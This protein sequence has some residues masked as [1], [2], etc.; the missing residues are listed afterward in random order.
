MSLRSKKLGSFVKFVACTLVLLW[1]GSAS[2]ASLNIKIAHGGSLEHQYHIG[3][4]EFKRL[5]EE[6][7]GGEIEITIF[8]Q[9]Q[10]GSERDLAESVRMGTVE[11][12][13][14]A[15]SNMAGFVP[16]LQVF[17]IPFL[18]T[19]Q[20]AV[21]SVLD[22]SIG[23]E[24]NG[25]MKGKG[26]A[27][28]SYWEVGFRNMTNNI[29]PI[30]K[31]EDASGLKI[32]VQEAK[33]WI[34]FMKALGA[35]ATPIPFGELY[36][37]LQQK[38]TDGEENPIATIYSMKYYEVQKYVSM[39][40]HTYEPV[41]VIANQQWFDGLDPKHQAILKDAAA[42]TAAFQRARLTELE[43]ERIAA[44][45]AAGTEVEEHP[46]IPAFV[47]ATKDLYKLIADSVPEELV[48]RIRDAIA[49]AAAE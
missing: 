8:P 38:V 9:G 45:R 42:K 33:I 23:E 15:A 39:T 46:D 5:V 41:L 6:A 12:G 40:R 14:L 26:F 10:L 48:F 7:S 28:L 21:Y 3:A 13:E 25:Y 1:A 36:T 24:L 34:E 11:I 35:V 43:K 47:E 4:E 27:N 18:F 31:P 22:G 20:K 30:I 37:A 17:G 16:E 32:R 49:K 29:R 2:A 19:G 44:I